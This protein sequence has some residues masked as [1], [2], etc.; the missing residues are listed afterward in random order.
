MLREDNNM[1]LDNAK[2]GKL[3]YH[4]TSIDNLDSIFE[5]GL[6]PRKYV[7]ENEIGFKDIADPEIID[8]RE[9]LGL[10]KYTPFH[11]HPY[12]AFDYAVK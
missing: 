9:L 12:T 2:N 6:L 5:N 7:R 3:L 1:G 10:D 11:F 4:L 8:K